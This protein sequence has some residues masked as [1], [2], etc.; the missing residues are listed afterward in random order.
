MFLAAA[1]L[2]LALPAA[3][4]AASPVITVR[5]VTVGS[6]G[7]TS[8]GIVPFTDAVYPSCQGVAE[9]S[10][11]GGG[12]IPVGGVKRSYGIGELEITVS[13]WVTFLN[14][15]DPGGKDRHRLYSK[16][17]SSVAWPKYGSINHSKSKA[18]G[19][20]YSVALPEWA[21]KPY[22]FSDFTRAARFVNAMQNGKVLKRTTTTV[23]A[24]E[25]TSYRVRLS[26]KTTTGMYDFSGKNK[27]LKRTAPSGF[28]IPS[29]DEWI[30]AA[31][32]DPAAGG[33]DAAVPNYWKYPT[34][35][36]VFGDGDATAP[37]PSVLNATTGAVTNAATQPIS[38][39]MNTDFPVP[40]WCPAQFTADQC[41]MINPFG[42]NPIE[43]PAMFKA[44]VGSVGQTAT[45]SP[46]GTLDQG[47]N[48]V[49][50]TDTLGKP[51][52]GTD[53]AIVWRRAH[54]GVA[55]AAA[56]QLW[57]SAVGLAPSNA[58]NVVNA[59]PWTGFRIGVV[60]SLVVK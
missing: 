50:W 5:T 6:P 37:T 12:C 19:T 15:V 45:R 51:P 39:Y 14:T 42:N 44:S 17:E 29:Q 36:G 53:K 10:P 22:A 38:T 43:Q 25:V 54:G 32:F 27:G 20:H 48:V 57:L 23:G 58:T 24:F 2:T 47:G 3:A 56:Y 30:K 31:Y 41:S 49:E 7:N 21:N 40:T 33:S 11:T 26:A 9:K 35:A 59:Y 13:Q 46:W 16:V 34:N 52:V 4:S 28:V 60:G 55:N 8:I 18:H 1:A